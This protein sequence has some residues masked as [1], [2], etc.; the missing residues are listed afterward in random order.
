MRG[1]YP[2]EDT[3]S[4]SIRGL[5][6]IIMVTFIGVLFASVALSPEVKYI[7]AVELHAKIRDCY[8]QKKHSEI[9]RDS[10]MNV[11]N[12]NCISYAAE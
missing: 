2:Q 6:L 9:I 1:R 12:F 3:N 4:D 11:I 8:A 7:D 10:R 5:L